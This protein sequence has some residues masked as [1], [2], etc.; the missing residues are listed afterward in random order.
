MLRSL[1]AASASAWILAS[2]MPGTARAQIGGAGGEPA[3]T[4]IEAAV[5]PSRA[6]AGQAVTAKVAID[7]A[8]YLL[9]LDP[10]AGISTAVGG[11]GA[12]AGGRQLHVAPTG[13]S[14]SGDAVTIDLLVD[15]RRHRITVPLTPS[16]GASGS[17][18]QAQAQVQVQTS[19]P[20]RAPLPPPLPRSRSAQLDPVNIHNVQASLT[21]LGFDPGPID[22]RWGPKSRQALNAFQAG[23]GLAGG[24]EPTHGDLA[25]LQRALSELRAVAAGSAPQPAT[26]ATAPAP[27]PRAPN[28][29]GS[30]D[31]PTE[32]LSNPVD[33]S[34]TDLAA[35]MRDLKINPDD[36]GTELV[37][38][39][40]E[41]G[42]K[43]TPG[44]SRLSLDILRA[45]GAK[46]SA[47]GPGAASAVPARTEGA[48][49][50]GIGAAEIGAEGIEAEGAAAPASGEPPAPPFA[51]HLDFADWTARPFLEETRRAVQ[52]ISEQPDE[53]QAVLSR[54]AGVY[55]AHGRS[56]DAKE[57]VSDLRRRGAA[58]PLVTALTEATAALD[59][60]APADAAL[61]KGNAPEARLWRAVDALYRGNAEGTTPLAA[62]KAP[63]V[64]IPAP[65]RFRIVRDAIGRLVEA[66][67][68]TPAHDLMRMLESWSADPEVTAILEYWRA[69][70][71]DIRGDKAKAKALYER[72]AQGRG[73][74]GVRARFRLVALNL[75][76]AGP[77]AA[78]D[79]ADQLE[80][81]A[82]TWPDARLDSSYNPLSIA[83]LRKAG[84]TTEAATRLDR[85]M[86]EPDQEVVAWAR[87]E[88]RGLLNGL[89]DGSEPASL[90]SR[91]ALLS[92]SSR[93]ATREPLL[94]P[95][96][97][98]AAEVLARTGLT[99]RAAEML[100]LAETMADAAERPTILL[101][102]ATLQMEAGDPAAAATTL[103]GAA[104]L[105]PPDSPQ[106]PD[107][108]ARMADALTLSGKPEQAVSLLDREK[109]AMAD[110]K[111][112]EAAM[113]ANV[114]AERW[115]WVAS[116]IAQSVP[117]R[118]ELAAER[119][120]DGELHDDV[121]RLASAYALAGQ[122]EAL[123]A[124]GRSWRPVMD[125]T[126]HASAFTA[127]TERA[128]ATTVRELLA[129][130]DRLLEAKLR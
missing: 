81:L 100:A 97:P 1:L 36:G 27:N 34:D 74:I 21:A 25:T 55:L 92:L 17:P 104:R 7:G 114:A 103:D 124:L 60:R 16:A 109:K 20:A 99:G 113:R 13:A 77:T 126:R 2:A 64:D 35:L 73:E 38:R 90:P 6:G 106:R 58:S 89:I 115:G 110:P 44:K 116:S 129:S 45:E 19:A 61:F 83:A 88:L 70:E 49:T 96:V 67:R 65:L 80:Q 86:R 37:L 69:R 9:Y 122:D 33:V 95:L 5:A 22:G 101:R 8:D 85:L 93:W 107:W 42:L 56:D 15:Q 23:R 76:D 24:D 14:V 30:P 79:M 40:S 127:L 98:E 102:R 78:S 11:R 66:S 121:L 118:P 54:L 112:A 12:D 32:R 128:Q 41:D 47:T 68:F 29:D 46:S 130:A 51:E 63:L 53:Q 111:V 43:A 108:L 94:R 26:V 59:G 57:L 71:F 62:L 84:R 72:L 31:R 4:P 18:V 91:L 39:L 105:I 3:I 119:L 117:P 82:A 125:S 10:G 75:P 48:R 87:D 52:T 123:D 50:E 28:H 120:G